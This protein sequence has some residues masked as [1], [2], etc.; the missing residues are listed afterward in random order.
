MANP[1]NRTI[2]IWLNQQ[3]I[4]NNLK[5]VR[6]AITKTTNE[7][8]K[9]PAYSDE[10]YEKSKKLG[11]L[12]NIYKQMRSE[13]TATGKDLKDAADA[14]D[15]F[16][17]KAGAIASVYT[18]A[19]AAVQRFISSTQEYVDAYASLD[20]AMTN[21]SKYTGLTR[22]EVKQLNEEF[23]RMDTRTPTEKLNALAADAGRLGITSKE[24]IKDFVEAADIINIALGE[25]L[26][27]D[28][29]KNIG[30][31]AQMFGETETMGLRGAMIATASERTNFPS[32]VTNICISAP[33]STSNGRSRETIIG[34]TGSGATR[35]SAPITARP[36][37][38]F[39]E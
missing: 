1:V 29:V 36:V 35:H 21:V 38:M 4:E 9:L 30:K 34:A 37:K 7:L 8:A 32:V 23:R 24:A 33:A 18:G 16:V 39:D 27:E 10:W 3:G 15:N 22:E 17:L 26:G 14:V 2:N 31:M 28:A 12:K 19:S 20:D 13:I 5:S 11:Q 25:D 6:A